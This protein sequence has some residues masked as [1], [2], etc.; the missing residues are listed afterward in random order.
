M[1]QS[2]DPDFARRVASYEHKAKKGK[3]FEAAGTVGGRPERSLGAAWRARHFR[4][5]LK[6][7]VILILV[8]VFAYHVAVSTGVYETTDIVMESS[9]LFDRAIKLSLYPDP[10]S[11]TISH[12]LTMG[13]NQFAIELRKI[14]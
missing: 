5:F 4:F 10:F 11:V 1:T 3:V 6:M 9:S 2:V 7:I 8:K 13:Q 12:Y 14:M